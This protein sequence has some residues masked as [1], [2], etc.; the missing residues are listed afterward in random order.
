MC[1]PPAGLDVPRG[2]ADLASIVFT[3]ENHKSQD[4]TAARRNARRERSLELE[5]ELENSSVRLGA[6]AG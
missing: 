2:A 6:W 3:L 5:H 1:R 4:F